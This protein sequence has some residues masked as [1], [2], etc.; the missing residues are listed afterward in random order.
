MAS[1]N[2]HL[3]RINK[4]RQVKQG[5]PLKLLASK[6]AMEKHLADEPD[7]GFIEECDTNAAFRERI[8]G[9]DLSVNEAE[10]ISR[11]KSLT[12]DG[13]IDSILEPVFLSLLDGT[14]RAC[15]IGIRQGI[16]PSRLYNECKTFTY[17]SAANS[18]PLESYSEYLNERQN[19]ENF[20]SQSEY[21]AR[22]MTR[23]GQTLKMPNGDKMEEA[24]ES[25]FGQQ[26]RAPDEYGGND[27]YK[28]KKHAKSAGEPGQAAQVDHVISCYEI[29]NNLKNNKA[30]NLE[31]IKT[32]VNTDGNL[33]VTSQQNN[34]GAKTG[35]HAKSRQQLQ[36]EI[37][38][39]YVE[40]R[41]GKKVE[42]HELSEEEIKTRQAMV[43]TMDV[44]Q[45]EVDDKTNELVFKNIRT[46][47][48]VQKV[49]TKDATVAA[50][51]QSIGDLVLF[52]IKPLYFE[53]RDCLLKGIE[54]GVEATSFS[55]AL[56][57]RLGRMKEHILSQAVTLLKDVA[58]GFIRNFLSMLLEGIVNC[59]V[60]VFKNVMRMVKEGFKVVMQIVPILNNSHSTLAQKG[61]A[62]LKL[63]AGSLS[64][65]AAIG[66]ESWLSSLGLP[67]PLSIILSS[68]LTA[69]ITALVMFL[70]DKLDLFGANDQ[71]RKKR[72][73]EILT[74]EVEVAETD[75]FEAIAQ[76]R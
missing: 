74:Q 51:H 66:L 40:T 5:T 67:G 33:A 48:G 43:E 49:L 76:L 42:R 23:N 71:L 65:F 17:T 19:I 34:A 32:I 28:N 62:I 44:A 37:D 11:L 53:L 21:K 58:L 22:S 31:D 16:T 57:I 30:L 70:L 73:D 13:A 20:G 8:A 3:S 14:M 7:K 41:K 46:D 9:F 59:F 25:Y 35:K 6:S 4:L 52:I 45:K 56:S 47:K 64:I 72:I 68:V 12:A 75:M 60:G 1:A 27:I 10:V 55:Q 54:E 63:V 61:D 15:N 50:G 26:N 69:V 36:Q 39:G 38:Q 24:K 2:E 29:C 18:V